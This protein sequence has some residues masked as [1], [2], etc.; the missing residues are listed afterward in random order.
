MAF[1]LFSYA[2]FS[3]VAIA[4]VPHEP[5]VIWYGAHWGV[6]STAIVATA[7]TL[8]A[9]FVDYRVFMPVV[10]RAAAHPVL[11]TGMVRRVRSLFARAPFAVIAVSGITPLP[12]L[13]FKAVAFAERYPMGR[14]LLAV[15]AGRL[16]RYV[17]LAW[18][19]VVLSIP[20]WV[21]VGLC[22]IFLTP[23]L[24]ALLWKRQSAR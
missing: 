20:P 15:G 6:W 18:L 2:F 23:S 13:P 19:G 12:A 4:V 7:G 9:S 14:Y 21:F 5:V 22:L 3:N 16:P 17:L 11:A 1:A 8:V 24:R 10:S